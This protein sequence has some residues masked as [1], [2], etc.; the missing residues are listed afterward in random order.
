MNNK[1][2]QC[3]CCERIFL[4]A[5]DEVNYCTKKCKEDH[6]LFKQFELNRIEERLDLQPD[7]K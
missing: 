3:A 1:L 5:S 6:N 2:S 7:I 4:V